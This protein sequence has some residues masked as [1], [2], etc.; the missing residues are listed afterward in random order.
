MSKPH[1]GGEYMSLPKPI[2]VYPD[3]EL[4]ER[5]KLQAKKERRSASNLLC[6]LAAEHC[7]PLTD[8]QVETGHSRKQ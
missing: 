8:L 3:D 7:A 1:K 2:A 4:R 6:T 5:I